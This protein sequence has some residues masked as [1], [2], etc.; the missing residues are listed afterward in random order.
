[1]SENAE[2]LALLADDLTA[3]TGPQAA[4]RVVR[5]I[6]R[7][8]REMEEE[9]TERAKIRAESQQ[10]VRRIDAM[11]DVLVAYLDRSFDERRAVFERAF[12]SL[13]TALES[14]SHDDVAKV[15][16][17]IVHLAESSP[18]KALRDLKATRNALADDGTV[19]EF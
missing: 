3:I 5:D 18:F 4:M 12:S 13:D 6:C 11:R 16:D 17:S 2:A 19:W 9:R 15:L 1:M 14:G 10:V 7:L 8:A